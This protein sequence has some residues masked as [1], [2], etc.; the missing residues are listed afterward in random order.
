MIL[1]EAYLWVRGIVQSADTTFKLKCADLCVENF[2]REFPGN[3][4]GWWKVLIDLLNDKY[5]ELQKK[6]L[7]SNQ[8]G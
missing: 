6:A 3:D 2:K 1:H 7:K 5:V 8:N 4:D